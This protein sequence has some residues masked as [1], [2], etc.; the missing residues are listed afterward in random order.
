V[1]ALAVLVVQTVLFIAATVPCVVAAAPAPSPSPTPTASP[2]PPPAVTPLKQIG[3]VVG[4]SANLIGKAAAASAGTISQEQIAT[5]PVL[6]P[7]EVLEAIPGLVISQHSGEGKA[8]QYYLRGFQLDHGTD[9]ESTV[10]GIPINLP[11]H[12]HGQGYSDINWLMPELISYVEFKKGPYYADQGDF[13]TAGAYNLY[14]RNTIDPVLELGTGSYGFDRAFVAAS[15]PLGRGQLLYAAEF[16]HDNGSFVKPDEYYKY[17]GV[18]RYSLSKGRND[19][20]VT[21]TGYNGPFDSTDQIPQRLVAEG[22]VGRYGYV[23]PSDGGNTYRYALSAQ[24][25]H[26]DPNGTTRFNAYGAYSFLDLFS[27]FTY[28]LSDGDDY[29]NET[30]NPVTCDP[31][32]RS[33]DPYPAAHHTS[34]YLSYCPAYNTAPRGAAYH[35]VAQP[36]YTFACGDQRE[37]VDKRFVSGFDV[38]RDF[39]GRHTD[40][41]IGVG[42]RNDN[43][44]ENGLFLTNDRNRYAAGTLSDDHIAQWDAYAYAQSQIAVGGRLRIM[45]GLRLDEYRFS[46]GAY[47]PAN[48]GSLA[49]G[50][51]NPKLNVAYAATK[52]SEFYL[53]FGESFHSNDARSFIGVDDPQTNRSYDPNGQ[54]VYQNSPLVR[55]TGEEA[56]Y[57]YSAGNY[58][59][60]AALFQLHLSNE[61]IFDG[62]HGT[63]S[64]G[65]PTLRRG[66]ELSNF[67]SPRHWLTVDA[68]LAAATAR[69][70]TDPLHE[71]TAVPESLNTVIAAGATID[72]PHYVASLRLRYFGPRVLDT[73]GDAFSTPSLLLS[74]GITL[75][76]PHGLSW[77][78]SAFN[79]LNADANDV[80]YYYAS[81]LPQDAALPANA[82]NP[83][84]NPIYGS[85]APGFASV[86]GQGINDY[87]FHP[88][89]KR[90]LRLALT[91][92][93]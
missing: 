53:D 29:Y 26:R 49:T 37:Q 58:T 17:N 23:D 71:G 60:T 34:D 1:R 12:A 77:S 20:A 33:C 3:R 43:V 4:R 28:D 27:N 51:L 91:K 85:R 19:Y 89:E 73:Q 59:A 44:P 25:T 67:W 6:R 5:R 81:W 72:E 31:A 24:A 78:L 92:R 87:H 76:L 2:V 38:A 62:D 93:L 41:T 32:Y 10:A 15:N 75:K 52:N 70:L 68:D 18:L 47:N 61:L 40:N 30:A 90:S 56:G 57:R 88:S 42:V 83:A 16:A 21:A 8:N 13:S 35:S 39:A 84:I 14:Y 69:F 65:G 66:I 86:N 36:K 9:L 64:V 79:L 54:P 11:S 55:A 46:V 80:E 82:N 7:G 22:D 48:S 63:T 74:G 50:M 45:P